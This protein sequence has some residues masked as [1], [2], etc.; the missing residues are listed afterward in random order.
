MQQIITLQYQAM[1]V[2]FQSDAW[3]NATQIAK[4]FGKRPADYLKSERTVDYMEALL[5]LCFPEKSTTTK[6][7]VEQ[8]QQVTESVSDRRKILTEQ[9]QLVRVQN[10][11]NS[12]NIGTWLHPK[13]AIDFARW[14]DARFAVWCDMQIEKLLQP[15]QYG[16]KASA[17][18]TDGEAKQLSKAIT[19]K[20]TKQEIIRLYRELHDAYRITSYKNVPAGKLDEALTFLGLREPTLDE[21]VLTKKRDLIALEQKAKALPAPVQ[22]FEPI[23]AGCV[24]LPIGE[25]D[26]LKSSREQLKTVK[27]YLD[28]HFLA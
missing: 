13:L 24:V 19:S 14:L 11:G 9:N 1:P 12:E 8:N 21:Y 5:E 2:L 15:L 27:N 16:L 3:I 26:G 23:A 18:I 6:I 28:N 7:V 17:F 25:Y 20:H 22:K 4:Q 10:G